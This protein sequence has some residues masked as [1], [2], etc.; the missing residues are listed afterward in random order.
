M[1]PCDVVGSANKKISHIKR[2]KEGSRMHSGLQRKEGKRGSRG[3]E[4]EEAKKEKCRPTV[5]HD[6][7]G[8][9]L[10]GL[11]ELF[12]EILLF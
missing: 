8:L 6:P 7:P 4:T 2:M 5:R 1:T 3:R 9:K 10:S 12:K 11:R